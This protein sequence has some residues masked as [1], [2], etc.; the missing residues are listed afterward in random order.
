MV[1]SSG[2][3]RRCRSRALI[4]ADLNVGILYG[5]PVTALV[6]VGILMA[7]WASNNK[8]RSRRHPLGGAD[9]LTRS[10]GL[11]SSVAAHRPL[12]MQD[13]IKAQ[14]RGRGRGTSA[15]RSRSSRSSLF[16]SRSPR[17]TARRSTCQ[18]SPELVAGFATE[19]SG[20]RNLLFFMAGGET[21]TSSARSS[22]RPS[23]RRHIPMTFENP[24]VQHGL[25]FATFF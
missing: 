5:R 21:S 2:R 7:G 23:R 11:R 10:C 4:V 3:S 24:L 19:H 13:I 14:A 16:V 20:M 15:N 9:H 18:P 25:E 22:R 17:A 1:A 12:S 6:V 8:G